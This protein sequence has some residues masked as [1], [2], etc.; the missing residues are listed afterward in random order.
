MNKRKQIILVIAVLLV[1]FCSFVYLKK[2]FFSPSKPKE[3][4]RKETLV[5]DSSLKDITLTDDGRYVLVSP[6]DSNL[7]PNDLTLTRNYVVSS[8]ISYDQTYSKEYKK[9]SSKLTAFEILIYDLRKK[10][11]E[12][13]RIDLKKTVEKYTSE[14]SLI[15]DGSMENIG[16]GIYHDNIDYLEIFVSKK[17]NVKERKKLLLNLENG[18]LTEL[19]EAMEEVIL[20]QN[21]FPSLFRTNLDDILYFNGFSDLN[22]LTYINDKKENEIGQDINLSR[23]FP[24][25]VKRLKKNRV[26]KIQYRRGLVSPADYYEDLRHWFAPVG[27]DKLDIVAKDYE[28]NEETPLNNYQEFIDWSKAEAEKSQERIKANGKKETD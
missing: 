9:L 4:S 7:Q 10:N 14:Y 5:F 24:D 16:Y 26:T 2:Q 1:A 21:S 19:S 22:Y 3:D 23:E 6:K 28:T 20:A 18:K 17:D 11:F 27:Q 25:L 8:F 12:E 13:K 15:D